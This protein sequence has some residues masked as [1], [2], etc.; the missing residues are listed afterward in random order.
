MPVF[1]LTSEYRYIFSLQG[2]I[3]QILLIDTVPS[4]SPL[5]TYSNGVW[6]DPP[7]ASFHWANYTDGTLFASQDNVGLYFYANTSVESK[8]CFYRG[9]QRV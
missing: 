2:F 4:I 3:S 6:N 8:I 9:Q 5:V 1:N 7:P